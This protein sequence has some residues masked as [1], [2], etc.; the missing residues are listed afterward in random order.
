MATQSPDSPIPSAPSSSESAPPQ[1]NPSHSPPPSTTLHQWKPI[2]LAQY[3]SPA[4]ADSPDAI[5]IP[6][7]SPYPSAALSH[8]HAPAQNAHRHDRPPAA[9][10]PDAP[11]PQSSAAP[12]LSST[13]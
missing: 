8:R 12:G 9:T 3:I 4:P 6:P 10:A 1:T 7:P 11:D 5:G 13:T 2:P